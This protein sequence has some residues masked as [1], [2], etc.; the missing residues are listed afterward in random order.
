MT[1][2]YDAS[3]LLTFAKSLLEK[4]GMDGEKSDSVA[5]IL[6]EGDLLGHTTHGLHLLGPYLN[7]LEKGTMAKSGEPKVLADH[8][9]AVTWDG[10]RLPGPWLVERGIEVAI[11]RAK[12]TGTGTVLI[13]RS[14][15]IACLAAYLKAVAD[16]GMMIILSCSDPSQAT[17]VPHGGTRPVYTPDPI[18]A[19]W[20]TDGDPV[21][22]DVSMSI[23]T[24]GMTGRLKNEGGRLPGKWTVDY[25][26][27]PSDDPTG[28]L[29]PVGG[30]D[31]GHKGYALALLVEAMTSA[32]CG[33]GRADPKDGWGAS[34]FIQVFDPSLIGGKD[35][36]IRQSTFVADAC[37]T[38]PP[39]EGFERVRLP[40]ENG[41]RK[42]EKQLRDGVELYPTIMPAL[43]TW[44][45]KL[46]V[47]VSAIK[48]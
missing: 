3:S 21:M 17:V 40:G 1:T 15:H 39:R 33:F 6:L 16:R 2:R 25:A 44:A 48:R 28:W 29:L 34:V 32:L 46:N 30:V 47:R 19:G 38:N 13:R 41:L 10:L 26:G 4:G 12:K 45:K 36:F 8:P 43:E 24:N 23:T 20:P 5:R 9:A 31:H 11:D 27:Q 18:A 35:A 14:H 7:E 22:I 42:R 37:R